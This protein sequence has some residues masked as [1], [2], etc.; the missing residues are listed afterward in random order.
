MMTQNIFGNLSRL[1]YYILF[2]TSSDG[3]VSFFIHTQ[4]KVQYMKDLI[5]MVTCKAMYSK[6]K[7]LPVLWFGMKILKYYAQQ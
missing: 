6:I 1:M 7:L 2:D 5:E 3:E 4:R